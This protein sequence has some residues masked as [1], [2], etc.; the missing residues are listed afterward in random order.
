MT[1][2]LFLYGTL[3]PA[4][5]T[6]EAT[7]LITGLRRIG[8]ARVFG[9]LYDLGE[10]PGAVLDSSARTSIRGELFE[11]PNNPSILSAL[12]KYEE[13]DRANEKRSLF[14]RTKTNVEVSDGRRLESWIYV[15]NR[16]PGTA[17]VIASGDYSQSQAA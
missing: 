1:K 11:L 15:Y 3:R 4:S 5:P 12:D 13:F 16:D 6:N 9:R 17:P 10:Y 2:Y 14:I 8:R 7:R